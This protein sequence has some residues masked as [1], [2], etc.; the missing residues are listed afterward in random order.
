MV[1]G[2]PLPTTVRNIEGLRARTRL[3]QGRLLEV[4]KLTW[5]QVG[6]QRAE[7][8][9]AQPKAKLG[10]RIAEAKLI[11]THALTANRLHCR[12]CLGRATRSDALDW[13][14]RR[15]SGELPP[16]GVHDTHCCEFQRGLVMCAVCGLWSYQRG[17]PATVPGRQA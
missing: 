15:C 12:R 4:A 7:R 3:V 9:K 5:T 10:K 14:S 13:L 1:G 11:T 16:A 6:P 17:L 2:Q 8:I